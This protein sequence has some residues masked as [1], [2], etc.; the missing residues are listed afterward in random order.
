M[1]GIREILRRIPLVAQPPACVLRAVAAPQ[2]YLL[3]KTGGMYKEWKRRYFVLDSLGMLYY[4]SNK[5]RLWAIGALRVL[6]VGLD[7]MSGALMQ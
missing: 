7:S 2:G 5:V 6:S 4:F 3:K 1:E